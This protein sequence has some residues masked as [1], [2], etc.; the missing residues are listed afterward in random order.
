MMAAT[1]HLGVEEQPD[2]HDPHEPTC[3]LRDGHLEPQIGFLSF[4]CGEQ[5]GD[6]YTPG[7]I[8]GKGGKA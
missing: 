6:E 7:H 4:D 2:S 8:N 5:E 3:R 1:T